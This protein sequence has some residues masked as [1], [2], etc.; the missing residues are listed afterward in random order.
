MIQYKGLMTLL[1]AESKVFEKEGES[2]SYYPVRV[3][4]AGEIYPCKGSK[5]QVAELTA[6]VG[7]EGTGHVAV[8]SR[9]E[10]ISLKLLAFK[11]S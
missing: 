3:S 1:S 9:K 8:S 5:E 11:A 7:K 10:N 2:I 4:I 6:L